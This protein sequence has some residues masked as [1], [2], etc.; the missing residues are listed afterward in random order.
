[1]VL[2][3]AVLMTP[4]MHNYDLELLLCGALSVARRPWVADSGPL[5]AEL[6]V[7][8]AWMLPQLVVLLNSLATPISPLLILPL[9]FLA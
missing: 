7:L 4:S 6:F 8:I 3:A 9:L 2:V 1:M 5:R